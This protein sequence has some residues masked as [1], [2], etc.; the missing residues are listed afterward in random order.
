M[1]P[2]LNKKF[3]KFQKYKALHYKE[4]YFQARSEYR[5]FLSDTKLQFY[6]NRNNLLATTKNPKLFWKTFNNTR[7]SNMKKNE[8]PK[9]EWMEHFRKLLSDKNHYSLK[10]ETSTQPVTDML[11][12]CPITI[13]ELS[14]VLKNLKL[15]KTAGPDLLPNEIYKLMLSEEVMLSTLLVIF[16]KIITTGCFPEQWMEGIVTLIFKK[17]NRNIPSNYRPITLFNTISKIF[18][19]IL[20]NRF[21]KWQEINKKLPP[22]QAGFRKGKSCADQIFILN[23]LLTNQ[24]KKKKKKIFAVFIDLSAAFDSLNHDI[25]W[26]QLACQGVSKKFISLIQ[27]MYSRA[28]IRISLNGE[29]TDAI[30]IKKGVLQGEPLSPALFNAYIFDIAE[31]LKEN[32]VRPINLNVVE[33][34]MLLFADDIILVAD[35]KV[36]LQQK[37][38]ILQEYFRELKLSINLNKTKIVVFRNGGRLRNSDKWFLNGEEILIENNYTYLGVNFSAVSLLKN[39]EKQFKLKAK[40]AMSQMYKSLSILKIQKMSTS[41][42][43]FDSI[44]K[45]TLF[46]AIPTWISI[47]KNS[48]ETIQNEFIKKMLHLDRKTPGALVRREFERNPLILD[49]FG[50]MLNYWAHILSSGHETLLRNAYEMT[51]NDMNPKFSNWASMLKMQLDKLGFSFIWFYQSPEA[52]HQFKPL[53]LQR[54]KDQLFQLDNIKIET[55]QSFKYYNQLIYPGMIIPQLHELYL[56]INILRF[57]TQIRLNESPLKLNNLMLTPLN[58]RKCQLCD[59][60]KEINEDL[61]HLINIC[62]HFIEIRS[63]KEFKDLKFPQIRKNFQMHF[64]YLSLN[65][66]YKTYFIMKLLFKSRELFIS[67]IADCIEST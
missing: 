30:P 25:L 24:V 39:A 60:E 44:I 32:N 50:L 21:S 36:S 40:L 5:K 48:I 54:F 22:E 63:S 27:Q 29:L 15:N 1:I 37:I 56:P 23:S 13:D 45:S 11:L 43:I 58:Q 26:Q 8:I 67:L 64:R 65:K 57:F 41:F 28:S 14:K 33:L 19:S 42:K 7:T 55:T 10:L 59:L 49:A 47:N 34:N 51:L 20:A 6:R 9:K 61:H 62:P 12:D 18:S 66:I 52:I 16:N 31:Q 38:N 35:T 53:I 46:Y 2:I 17:G 4:D 3:K